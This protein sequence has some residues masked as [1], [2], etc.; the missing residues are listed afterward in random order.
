MTSSVPNIR[1]SNE[2]SDPLDVEG[3]EGRFHVL[4]LDDFS[5]SEIHEILDDTQGM[6]EVLAR[7]IKKVPTLRGRVVVTM[8]YEAST[9]TRIYF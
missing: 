4:D 5:A 1:L 2:G 8:F 3:R 6:K 9:M 7:D